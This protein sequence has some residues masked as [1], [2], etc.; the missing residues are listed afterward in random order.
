MWFLL[1]ILMKIL[2]NNRSVSINLYSDLIDLE[3]DYRIVYIT[4]RKVTAYVLQR[5]DFHQLPP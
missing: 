2:S 1:Q 4:W 3:P 5:T